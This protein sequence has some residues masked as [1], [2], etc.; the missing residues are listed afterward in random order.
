L[1]AKTLERE[2]ARARERIA[3]LDQRLIQLNAD[4]E[5]ERRLA[6]DAE[7]ALGRL[8][9]EEETLR[10]EAE[11]NAARRASADERVAADDEVLAAAEKT[12][13]D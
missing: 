13:A 7:A 6:G 8:S 3:E 11:T 9:A 1:P 2:E 10:R 4:I 12:F 5:R